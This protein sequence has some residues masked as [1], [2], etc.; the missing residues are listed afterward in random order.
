VSSSKSLGA[1]KTQVAK[2]QI[3]FSTKIGFAW[4]WLPQM[5]VKKA[6]KNSIVLSFGLDRRIVHPR[7]KESLG[8]YPGRWTHHV[9]IEKQSDFDDN[10]RAWLREAHEFSKNRKRKLNSLQ[11]ND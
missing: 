5:W 11:T 3:S 7:I 2:T 6:P 8:T 9:V 4:L 10:V 1:V